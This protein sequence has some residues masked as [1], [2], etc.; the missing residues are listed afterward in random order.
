MTDFTHHHT[1]PYTL[2]TPLHTTH[3]PYTAH[4]HLHTTHFLHTTLCLYFTASWKA[5]REE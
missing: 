2:H 1:L 5:C 3:F 4:T